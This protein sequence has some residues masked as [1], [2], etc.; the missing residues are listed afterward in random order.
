MALFRGTTPTPRWLCS[1]PTGP[2]RPDPSRG[3]DVPRPDAEACD[4]PKPIR[5]SRPSMIGPDAVPK[6]LDLHGIW[7]SALVA[8]SKANSCHNPCRDDRAVPPGGSGPPRLGLP[9]D[10]PGGCP[11]I[12]FVRRGP[13]D[14]PFNQPMN[15]NLNS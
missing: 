6:S 11:E 15:S 2:N 13:M 9:R 12:G 4:R 1:A 5:G 7:A 14:L 10:R 3:W 8:P